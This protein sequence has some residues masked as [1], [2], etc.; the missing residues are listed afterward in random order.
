MANDAGNTEPEKTSCHNIK[1]DTGNIKAI[2]KIN[3]MTS[4]KTFTSTEVCNLKINTFKNF[5]L[6]PAILKAMT[7]TTYIFNGKSFYRKLL[8]SH[9]AFFRQRT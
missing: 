2:N 6:H 7:R 4:R 8:H 9:F 1:P 3:S 5:D